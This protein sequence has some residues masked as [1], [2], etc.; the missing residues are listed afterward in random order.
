MPEVRR[1]FAQVE[2]LL[3][4]LLISPA[5]SC[6]AEWSFSTRR[7]MKPLLRST[8]T[9]MR[10]SHLMVCNIH[11]EH[12][13]ALSPYATARKFIHRVTDTRLSVFREFEV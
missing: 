11:K 7:R 5:R 3:R 6:A 12:L 8:M 1:L 10:L 4:L 9:Q 2:R 13:A